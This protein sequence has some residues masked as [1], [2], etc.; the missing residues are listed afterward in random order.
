MAAQYFGRHAGR[1]AVPLSQ[2]F[3]AII[4]EQVLMKVG[5]AEGRKGGMAHRKMKILKMICEIQDR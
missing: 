2:G 3:G 5:M 1:H 4:N